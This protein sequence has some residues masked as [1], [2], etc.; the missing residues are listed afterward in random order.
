L[1]GQNTSSELVVS[2][3]TLL[4]TEPEALRHQYT[5]FIGAM[6]PD[7]FYYALLSALQLCEPT[8]RKA[9][10][11]VLLRQF[12]KQTHLY[13]TKSLAV[14][15]AIVLLDCAFPQADTK[16]PIS[17]IDTEQQQVIAAICA[18][19]EIWSQWRWDKHLRDHGLPDQRETLLAL[20]D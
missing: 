8:L 2:L 20:G 17:S 6:N 19:E 1:T 14:R 13:N 11:P 16:I 4:E 5:A 9:A 10:L 3:I 18:Y 12:H 15:I 7:Y